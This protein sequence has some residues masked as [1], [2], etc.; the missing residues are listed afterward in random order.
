LEV[1]GA[2]HIEASAGKEISLKVFI[3]S[4]LEGTAGVVA[5]DQTNPSDK[6]YD[7]AVA[8]MLGE[9]NAAIEGALDAGADEILVCDSHNSM[10]NLDPTSLHPAARLN[11]GGGKPLSMMQGIDDSFDVVFFTGYHAQVGEPGVL[12]HTYWGSVV[13]GVRLNN[14]LV[15]ETGI[16][17][18][19][20]GYFGVPVALV[21]GDTVLAKEAENLL[22][23]I[24]SAAV[25]TPTGRF[26]ATSIHPTMARER[27]REAARRAVLR[28]GDME[29]FT[30][31]PPVTLELSV[32]HVSQ[33][34]R[35]VL[36]PGVERISGRTMRF[37]HDDYITVF[38]C[39]LAAC[40]LA[41]SA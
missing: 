19:V 24:E 10:R 27:I 16:N 35:I 6:D 12:N 20:A 7:K 25:K 14:Q 31:E 22:G 40:I 28:A 4:D 38:R 30:L 17:A 23:N 5:W 41:Q 18:A 21:T 9:V 2:W 39:M 26:S 8:L 13:S 33:M 11:Q 37:M 3:S 29:P 34:D 1:R 32:M 15:G 36:I